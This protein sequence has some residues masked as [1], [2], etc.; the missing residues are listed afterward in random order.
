VAVPSEG[1]GSDRAQVRVVRGVKV[2]EAMA[3]DLVLA[4]DHAWLVR[5]AQAAESCVHFAE[6]RRRSVQL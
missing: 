6:F 2:T 5:G 1:L 3:C 4:V